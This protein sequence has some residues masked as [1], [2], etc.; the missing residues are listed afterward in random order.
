MLEELDKN[1]KSI[2]PLLLDY[3]GTIP[4]EEHANV[5][6][7]VRQHYLKDKSINYENLDDLIHM[8]GDRIFMADAAKA[9]KEQ[10]KANPGKVWLYYYSYRAANSFSDFLSNSTIDLGVCISSI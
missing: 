2:A 9:A 5:A 10:A 6:R 8:V 1:W 4:V 3:N 7:K